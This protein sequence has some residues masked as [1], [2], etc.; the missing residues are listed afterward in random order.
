[1]SQKIA[2]LG[3]DGSGKTSTINFIKNQLESKGKKVEVF[4]MGWKQFQNPTLKFFSNIYLKSNYKKNKP[5]D[6]LDR[7]KE[8]SWF[9]YMIYYTEL[10]TRYAE[11][12]RSEADFILLDRYF[13]EEL[14]FARGLKRK[15]LRKFTPLPT[16]TIVLETNPETIRSRGHEVS[17]EKLKNFYDKLRELSNEFPMNFIDSS[18]EYE[19]IYE[20]V[21]N[22]TINDN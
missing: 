3:S 8:R 12:K 2:F 11:V 22:P 17:D 19:S 13:Y 4:T 9:F 21:I 20:E 7:F 5:Q 10:L 1:M 18:K 6:R 14:M 15:F 16:K